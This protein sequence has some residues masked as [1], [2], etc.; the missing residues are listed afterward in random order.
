MVIA[1]QLACKLPRHSPSPFQSS[2]PLEPP[3]PFRFFPQPANVRGT[4]C[5][6]T[7]PVTPLVS[8]RS[9]QFPSPRGRV[10]SPLAPPEPRRTTRHRFPSPALR[11]ERSF[12]RP[13]LLSLTPF[14]SHL[15]QSPSANSS[16]YTSFRETPGGWETHSPISNLRSARRTD[17]LRRSP[18]RQI[19]CNASSSSGHD[20]TADSA[21]ASLNSPL[22]CE[23]P[24]Q[25][26]SQVP[27]ANQSKF[28]V[29]ST[30]PFPRTIHYSLSATHF[31]P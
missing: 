8:M 17:R 10:H 12:E 19:A 4:F 7:P 15:S 29:K 11:V 28:W 16:P 30:L 6:L 9:A 5:H 26:D 20:F 1:R 3:I 23:L 31:L 22:H 25:A 18:R 14:L 24:V 2:D 21:I 27:G 13:L